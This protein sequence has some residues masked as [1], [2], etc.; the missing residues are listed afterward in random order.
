M[1]FTKTGAYYQFIRQVP[2]GQEPG[3]PDI[4]DHGV[5]TTGV[6]TYRGLD[7]KRGQVHFQ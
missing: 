1:W 5:E 2:V 7:Q 4:S 6:S 3:A